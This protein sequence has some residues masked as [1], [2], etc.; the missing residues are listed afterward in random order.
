MLV[1]PRSGCHSER[2]E[3]SG[4]RSTKLPFVLL[5]KATHIRP[6]LLQVSGHTGLS[7]PRNRLFCRNCTVPSKSPTSLHYSDARHA[8]LLLFPCL[9]LAL[10]L[11]Y[12]SSSG[13]VSIVRIVMAAH[14][15]QLWRRRQLRE[16]VRPFRGAPIFQL[17]RTA[18]TTKE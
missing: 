15:A 8:K 17:A 7:Q 3:E 12:Y 9:S 11:S 4:H 14:S 18:S 10:R 1:P 13:I 2:S 6:A 5:S 16:D